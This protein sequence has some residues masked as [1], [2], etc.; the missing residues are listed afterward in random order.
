M[1]VDWILSDLVSQMFVQNINLI[2]VWVR[3]KTQTHVKN[4]MHKF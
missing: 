3:K 2:P 4:F 1:Q